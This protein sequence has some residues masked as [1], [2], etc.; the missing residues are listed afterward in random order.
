MEVVVFNEE[1]ESAVLEVNKKNKPALD[2]N[3]KELD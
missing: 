1:K 3:K 2:V